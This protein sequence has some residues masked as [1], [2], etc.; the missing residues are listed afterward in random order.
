MHSGLHSPKRMHCRVLRRLQKTPS[1]TQSTQPQ[2]L[3]HLAASVDELV[4]DLRGIGLL[5]QRH[6]HLVKQRIAVVEAC[7]KQPTASLQGVFIDL[8]TAAHP[9][10]AKPAQANAQADKYDSRLSQH[11]A[12]LQCLCRGTN[13]H[14]CLLAFSLTQQSRYNCCCADCEIVRTSPGHP[15]HPCPPHACSSK[16]IMA[17][18]DPWHMPAG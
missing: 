17:C 11:N 7:A 16:W 1:P 4:E 10:N 6:L 8:I 3:Q 13:Q 2:T 14:C 18:A 5:L 9:D 15:N 12:P